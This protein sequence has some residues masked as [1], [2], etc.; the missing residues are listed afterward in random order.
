MET[1]REGQA[2]QRRLLRI[3]TLTVMR[4]WRAGVVD[5][6]VTVKRGDGDSDY[7]ATRRW[8]RRDAMDTITRRCRWRDGDVDATVMLTPRWR[9]RWKVRDG[10][11]TLT[12]RWRDGDGDFD[13]AVTPRWRWRDGYTA[14]TVSRQWRWPWREVT[15]TVAP[16][17]RCAYCIFWSLFAFFNEITTIKIESSKDINVTSIYTFKV[18]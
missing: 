16:L 5:A 15:M 14:V 18:G 8:W 3:A 7:D 13:A 6:T 12:W 17:N 2:K 10:S 1:R 11:A 9:W 4:W